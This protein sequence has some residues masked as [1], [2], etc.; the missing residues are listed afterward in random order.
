M[1]TMTSYTLE[2]VTS[3]RAVREF[4]DFPKRL[5]RNEPHWICPLDQ[6][7]E[8]KFHLKTNE[9]LQEGEIIRWIA[10]DPKGKVVGRIAAFYNR[11]LVKAS[12]FQ[13]TGGCGYFESI[14]DQ[15]VANLL[16]DAARD[17]LKARGLEAMD[18][19][20]NF[21]DRDQW[22][23]LLVK[24]FE[25]TPLYTNPYNFEYYIRLFENYGF[26]N[27]FNQHTY[28]RALAEGLFP[29]NVY[30]RVK[31]LQ[32][33]GRYRFEHMDKRRMGVYAD[34]FREVY[35]QAWAGFSGIKPIDQEHAHALLNKMRPIID[36]QLMY[37]A[38]DGERPIG[39]FL[40]VPDLNG[41]IHPLKGHFGLWQ[42]LR[43]MWRLKVRRKASRIFA[44]IF[45]VVP[46]FQGKGIESGM[47]YTFEQAV[48]GTLGS[49]YH[50][51]ELAWI[52]DFNPVMM[53]MVENYVCAQKHKMHT[54]YRYLF[55]RDKEFHRAP[56]M[57]VRRAAK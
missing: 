15:Q 52:G 26:Q 11:E 25:F 54:T 32:E 43:F 57:S 29:D 20:I 44:I 10:R 30:Q 41:V 45:G 39:F 18:G 37:F 33:E 19:P 1:N 17:W 31:R 3:R 13:P 28:L 56:R 27:Y 2:E 5:Y 14:D 4:L 34:A 40:M 21:G 9:L 48:A 49:Q 22:W 16:F 51:L 8:N 12:E 6:D 35:N 53:R 7:I 46:E 42:K 38:Y 23:G 50:S 24:G 47:I 55:D 36:E